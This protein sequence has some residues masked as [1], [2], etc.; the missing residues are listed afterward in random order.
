MREKIIGVIGGMGPE[1]TLD[2]F[3]KVIKNTPATKDQE[4]LRMIIDNNPKVPDRTAAILGKGESPVEV[5]AESGQALARAGADFV[6][7]PCVSAHYFLDELRA[8]LT[9]P[10]LSAFDAIA[11]LIQREFPAMRTVGL[12]A[13]KGTIQG[14]RFADKIR[15]KGLTV[16]VP[17]PADQDRVMG[18]IYKIKG[19]ASNSQLRD[20]ITKTLV[21]VAHRL[22]DQGAEGIIAGCT[23]IP[24]VLKP[25]HLSVPLFDS[26]LILAQAAIREARGQGR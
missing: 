15:E 5:M 2:F 17:G 24:L 20:D 12:L 3:S 8:K 1:A 11:S 10:I 26:L 13:T 9:L 7:I 22:R 6:V 16:I 18:A 25:E 23:E 21:D 14:G 19:S 4:H